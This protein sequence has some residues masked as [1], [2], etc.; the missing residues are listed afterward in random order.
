MNR[1]VPSKKFMSL[2]IH[3]L[4]FEKIGEKGGP[5]NEGISV[6]VVENNTPNVLL[7]VLS[8]SL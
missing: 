7:E 2:K 4:W 3:G 8:R 1:S 5:K 6:E